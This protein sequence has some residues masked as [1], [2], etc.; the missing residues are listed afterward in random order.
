VVAVVAMMPA[1]SPVGAYVA[2]HRYVRTFAW[3][4]ISSAAAGAAGFGLAYF[5]RLRG[6]WQAGLTLGAVVLAAAALL[7]VR[8]A[9]GL[10][11]KQAARLF[12][13]NFKT[14]NVVLRLIY[15]KDAALLV[16]DQPLGRGGWG[17]DRSYRQIQELDYTA[18]ETHDHYAQTA[19]EAG[20]LGLGAFLTA[21]VAAMGSAWRERVGNPLAWSLASGALLIAGHSAIDF[22]LSFGVVWLLVWSLLAGAA[23]PAR[24]LGSSLYFWPAVGGGAMVAAVAG[25]L[26]VGSHFTDVAQAEAGAGRK[27]D[28]AAAAAKATRF[29][30]WDSA[31]LQVIGDLPS[32]ERAAE[33]DPRHSGV[34]FDLAVARQLA[35]DLKGALSEA[36]AALQAQPMV[37]AHHAKAAELVG[38]MLNDALHYN[39]LE[40]ARQ[41]SGRLVAMGED[42][43]R[44]QARAKELQHLWSSGRKFQMAP[45]FQLRYGQALFLSGDA[46]KA[47]TYLKEAA[48]VGLLG[49]EAHVWLYVI[50]ERR[51]DK[52]AMATLADKP[53]IR[54][55]EQNPVYKVIRNW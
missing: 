24:P 14:V 47:E 49:S 5:L 26:A 3:L 21:L 15:D 43:S 41:L 17:W 18:R 45:I 46:G 39:R 29:D 7:M 28:A 11:P 30:R 9:G 2:A 42:F 44:R 12:D 4:G 8:P 33:L 20:V 55:R 16:K 34:R 48:K 23:A 50:Y 35:G 36:E 6:R 13:I 37:A 1:L 27:E 19:V 10:M 32:L 38:V 54:F 25:L 31:P 40:E 53:W 22:N 52:A 51:G